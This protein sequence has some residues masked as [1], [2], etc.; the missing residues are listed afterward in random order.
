MNMHR[1][2]EIRN[3]NQNKNHRI[4]QST[5]SPSPAQHQH[6]LCP[7]LSL[8]LCCLCSFSFYR[9]PCAAF[10]ACSSSR[11]VSRQSCL[12]CEASDVRSGSPRIF[13][14]CLAVSSIS[15]SHRR[16]YCSTLVGLESLVSGAA[17]VLTESILLVW[18]GGGGCG[19][20]VEV[21]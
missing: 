9:E 7:A 20:M 4:N 5:P 11:A 3:Q 10:L 14:I 12:A 16:W 21:Q 1:R 19:G 2:N 15:C 17:F 8:S 13:W 18:C 6:A